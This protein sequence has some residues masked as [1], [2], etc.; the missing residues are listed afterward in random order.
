M[1]E[2][3]RG[4]FSTSC[5][6]G[7]ARASVPC[8]ARPC[9][10]SLP[11][12]ARS[13]RCP[14]GG[15]TRHRQRW[16]CAC[17]P[18]SWS[19]QP[20]GELPTAVPLF[21]KE[22]RL[23]QDAS[24]GA[25]LI[26]VAGKGAGTI[27][28][29]LVDGDKSAGARAISMMGRAGAIRSD[30]TGSF[31]IKPKPLGSGGN[32]AVYRAS[33]RCPAGE[34]AE[35][36]V[37]K[38]GFARDGGQAARPAEWIP[39]DVRREVEALSA[40]QRHPNIVGFHG[41]FRVVEHA[42]GSEKDG[43]QQ[44]TR[45]VIALQLC[46]QGDLFGMVSERPASEAQARDIMRGLMSALAHMH[47]LGI[48]HRDVKPQNVLMAANGRAMLADFGLA[49]RLSDAREMQ[50]HCGTP[51]FAAPEVLRGERYGQKVDC[52]GAGALLLFALTG[53]TLPYDDVSPR[54][55]LSV[56]DSCK[57]FVLS[58]LARSPEERPEAAEALRHEWTWRGPA[59][60]RSLPQCRRSGTSFPGDSSVASGG[61]APVPERTPRQRSKRS[62][63]LAG[64]APPPTA[65]VT[66]RFSRLPQIFAVAKKRGATVS[67]SDRPTTDWRST[68][69][70]QGTSDDEEFTP[71]PS[72]RTSENDVD[73]SS[74][75]RVGAQK[76]EEGGGG[77]RNS[78]CRRL[79]RILPPGAWDPS[80]PT[81][82]RPTQ[83]SSGSQGCG[84][85][86]QR[87]AA[88]PVAAPPPSAPPPQRPVLCRRQRR[89]PQMHTGEPCRSQCAA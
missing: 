65:T 7:A 79:R 64:A 49:C 5:M 36:V 88:A 41:L 6:D 28:L 34:G 24:S 40:A 14:M 74:T 4:C 44:V 22:V 46:Q 2:S 80:A 57:G 85:A 48:V 1:R 53:D 58:L 81:A 51:S 9:L 83:A 89:Q 17:K 31:S 66:K 45:W 23:G 10:V 12:S 39:Q 55:R 76:T 38:M 75:P 56:T 35:E 15:S 47:H 61:T 54:L 62:S 69:S 13:P 59:R 21:F 67:V 29:V 72:D 60:P 71:W 52:F 86:A 37:V 25:P 50:R 11:H 87:A 68:A 16:S 32:A 8:P 43:S 27:W 84:V 19:S 70:E 63:S 18:S 26:A 30:L 3:L 82:P 73:N 78:I 77:L 42:K 20:P 33:A